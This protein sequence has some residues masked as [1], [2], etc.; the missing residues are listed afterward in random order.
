VILVVSTVSSS[1]CGR[2][3]AVLAAVLCGCIN[4]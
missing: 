3:L 1:C 2:L 4:D